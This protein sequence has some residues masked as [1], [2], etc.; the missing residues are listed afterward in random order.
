MA[1]ALLL[2]TLLYR[3]LTFG[4]VSDAFLQTGV[5]TGVVFILV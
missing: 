1:Y 4:K 5:I 2:E 3:S